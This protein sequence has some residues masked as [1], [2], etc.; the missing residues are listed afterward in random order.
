MPTWRVTYR[1]A[2]GPRVDLIRDVEADEAYDDGRQITL[3]GRAEVMG[4][5]RQVIAL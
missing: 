2:F 4:R 3:Y 5:P 1:P